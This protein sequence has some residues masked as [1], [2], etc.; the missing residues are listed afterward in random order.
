MK[1]LK[2]YC[3]LK[4]QDMKQSFSSFQRV[5]GKL[6]TKP[7]TLKRKDVSG[8]VV[9]VQRHNST[10]KSLGGYQLTEHR[11]RNSAFKRSS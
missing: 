10:T 11:G 4:N 6:S 3:L 2:V 5:K 1:A 8:E 9:L 7:K